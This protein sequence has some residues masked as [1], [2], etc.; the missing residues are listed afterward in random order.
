MKILFAP[1]G[2]AGGLLAG[3]VAKKVFDFVWGLIDDKEAPRA[4]HRDIPVGKLVAALLIEGA[5]FRVARGVADHYARRGFAALTGSW[6][7]EAKPE[8]E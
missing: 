8:S 4:K 2:I 5:V 7:G 3:S 1:F 6:P